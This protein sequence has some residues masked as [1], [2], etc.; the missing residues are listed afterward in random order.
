M[1]HGVSIISMEVESIEASQNRSTPSS[2]PDSS[3]PT[4]QFKNSQNTSGSEGLPNRARRSV[5]DPLMPE[6][7]EATI[8]V[9]EDKEISIE[10]RTCSTDG[11]TKSVAPAQW[12]DDNRRMV[13]QK[14]D[15]SHDQH[16]PRHV[17][18]KVKMVV[19]NWG[20]GC[21]PIPPERF[22]MKLMLS[23]GHEVR[24]IPALSSS[25]R[26]MPSIQQISDY[27]TELV[28]AVRTSNIGKLQALCQA[29]KR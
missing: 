24:T 22:L 18:V 12:S 8:Y 19:K 5:S 3:M 11:C 10:R 17:C 20:V 29:G 6:C 2:N 26:K 21:S 4:S 16:G 15:G 1:D 23:R 27:D 9:D 7:V 14:R 25:A 28:H 13:K